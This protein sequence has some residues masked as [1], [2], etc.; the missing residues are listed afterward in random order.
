MILRTLETQDCIKQSDNAK[1]MQYIEE[2]LKLQ[3]NDDHFLFR[4]GF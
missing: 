2:G 4:E 1:Y 3:P